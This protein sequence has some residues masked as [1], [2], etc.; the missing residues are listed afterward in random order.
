MIII[1]IFITTAESVEYF[2]VPTS[3]NISHSIINNSITNK[4]EHLYLVTDLHPSILV[5]EWAS[6][7]IFTLELLLRMYACPS[8]CHFFASLLNWVDIVCVSSVWVV[9]VLHFFPAGPAFKMM[10]VYRMFL[11]LR[12]L[13]VVRLFRYAR[14]LASST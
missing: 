12:S 6:N 13:R 1:S 5:L 8:R 4:K 14:V 11:G 9:L 7:G 3:Y 2:R 10:T